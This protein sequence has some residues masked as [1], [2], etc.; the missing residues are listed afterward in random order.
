MKRIVI[1]GAE[2]SGVCAAYQA[3]S[4]FDNNNL[5][6][7]NYKI[8]LII[9]Y[10]NKKLG[11]V[12]TIGGLNAWDALG[13]GCKDSNNNY[14]YNGYVQGG[15]FEFLLY[16]KG[17]DW[18]HNA[19]YPDKG[20]WYKTTMDYSSDTSNNNIDMGDYL[21]N[22]ALDNPYIEL[23]PQMDIVDV[24]YE[25]NSTG[26]T[27]KGLYL[28]NIKRDPNGDGYIRWGRT[29]KYIPGDIF[30]DAS[31]DGK[32]TSF[33]TP[34]TTGRY[35][36]PASVRIDNNFTEILDDCEINLHAINPYYVGRQECA[37]LY[38]LM[39][40]LAN[41]NED[42][43]NIE[44]SHISYGNAINE[45]N[46]SVLTINDP[47]SDVYDFNVNQ[48]ILTS[49]DPYMIKTYNM[50]RNGTNSNQFWVNTFIRFNVDGR[51]HYRDITTKFSPKAMI[52]DN[53]DRDKAWV[54]CK[55]IITSGDFINALKGFNIVGNSPTIIDIADILYIRESVHLPIG[56]GALTNGSEN[57]N[58]AI[59]MNDSHSAGLSYGQCA[60]NHPNQSADDHN[61]DTCIGLG[62][63]LDD[64]HPY[65]KYDYIVEKSQNHYELTSAK[66]IA[67]PDIEFDVTKPNGFTQC[68]IYIPFECIYTD[69]L[70]NV[71]ISGNA[72]SISSFAWGEM[73]LLP[74]M[75]VIG[76]AAGVAAAHCIINNIDVINKVMN[77]D[78]NDNNI[79]PIRRIRDFLHSV[80][81]EKLRKIY[82]NQYETLNS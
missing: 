37:T 53:I 26:K 9:P 51:A 1:Y 19:T 52:S 7:N 3:A 39:E 74:N 16:N 58:Y 10:P 45:M 21:T 40:G 13:P 36:W 72:S 27:V 63:Y 32:L 48:H 22:R 24:Y 64:I 41:C 42:N 28:R 66:V 44:Y 50:G 82:D 8:S 47:N 78:P 34:V 79:K 61:Y 56:N 33:L 46:G 2:M 5:S 49:D 57:S 12:G 6:P 55:S 81:N 17:N 43:N 70:N 15:T 20:K 67:R 60:Y 23:L 76:D 14:Y 69:K 73:R 54:E 38:F 18:N 30:I 68:P 11:G 62:Y 31:D 65:K 77:P 25:S 75:C 59:T 29:T 71:I 4:Y 35:D 80:A